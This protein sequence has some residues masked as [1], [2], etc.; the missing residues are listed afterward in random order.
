M[1]S[2]PTREILGVPVHALTM[3]QVVEICRQAA[4]ARRRLMIAVVN[5]AKLV[6]MRSDPGLRASVLGSDLILADGMSVVWAS[7]LLGRGLPERVTGIGLFERLIEEA[8]REGHSVYFLGASQE[9][10]DLVVLRTRER[11][12]GL[13]IAGSRNG[14]FRDEEQ[15]EV[16]LE[17]SRARP[18]FL[19]V[20]ISTP[21]KEIFLDR[22]ASRAE[23]TVCHGVGGSF[24]ILAGKT[25]RAPESWQRHGFEWLY[26]VLQEPRRMWK[27]YLVTN[28]TF[29]LLVAR[30][31]LRGLFGARASDGR[32][33]G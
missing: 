27:R 16:A 23:V 19:F 25:A 24:D 2:L 17:I 5:A 8:A 1:E 11:H 31:W 29:I 9:V 21:K 15:E 22:W 20:G 33:V 7:R 28:T 10:L 26:R 30:E 3:D 13:Q 32:G 12:P 6:K 18:D 14:Y 4:L